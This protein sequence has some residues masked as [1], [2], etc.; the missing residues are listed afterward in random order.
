M[1]LQITQSQYEELSEQAKQRFLTWT[2]AKTEEEKDYTSA[3]R[4]IGHLIWFLDEHGDNWRGFQI[5]RDMT[6]DDENVLVKEAWS[7]DVSYGKYTTQA[8]ELC[9]ALWGAVKVILEG[10]HKQK[11]EPSRLLLWDGKGP[12]K[13]EDIKTYE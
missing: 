11:K 12:L 7:V 8:Y 4:T 2:F 5:Q 1:K 10:E 3:Y 9:D 6:E 13:P